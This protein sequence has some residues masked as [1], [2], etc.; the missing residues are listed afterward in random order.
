MFVCKTIDGEKYLEADYQLQC[1]G[2]SYNMHMVLAVGTVIVVVVGFP[3]VCILIV[4]FQWR[5]FST[6]SI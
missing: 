1:S 2:S 5:R 3:L 6:A 4:E